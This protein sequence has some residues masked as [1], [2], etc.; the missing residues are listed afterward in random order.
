MIRAMTVYKQISLQRSTVQENMSSE[1]EVTIMQ[2]GLAKLFRVE[3][4]LIRQALRDVLIENNPLQL[5]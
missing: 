3:D 2:G 4:M 1:K 5:D